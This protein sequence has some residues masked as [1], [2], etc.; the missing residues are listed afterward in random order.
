MLVVIADIF[1]APTGAPD[2]IGGSAPGAERIVGFVGMTGAPVGPNGT[3]VP[4]WP[5]VVGPKFMI[6]FDDPIG[7]NASSTARPETV[8]A[9]RL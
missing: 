6:G 1:G 8:S 2:I 3:M 5:P 9:A 7:A 4:G